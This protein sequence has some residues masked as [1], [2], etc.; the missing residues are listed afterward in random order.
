M[1]A[2]PTQLVL[3]ISTQFT[4]VFRCEGD[5]PKECLGS[6]ATDDPEYDLKL[7]QVLARVQTLELGFVDQEIWLADDQ[8][9]QRHLRLEA[10]ARADRRE[11][12]GRA[13]SAIT[14]FTPADLSF[15]LGAEDAEGYT[16]VAAVPIKKL[17]EILALAQI[18][19][20]Q[21]AVVTSSDDI[22]GFDERPVW[23]AIELASS[24]W[25][26]VMQAACFM[27]AIMVPFVLAGAAN[28]NSDF[29]G[30]L[31]SILAFT[32]SFSGDRVE[33]KVAAINQNPAEIADLTRQTHA[34]PAQLAPRSDAASDLLGAYVQ[35]HVRDLVVPAPAHIDPVSPPLAMPK[36]DPLTVPEMP[37]HFPGAFIVPPPPDVGASSAVDGEPVGMFHDIKGIE[38]LSATQDLAPLRKRG[39]GVQVANLDV[40]FLD[41]LPKQRRSRPIDAAPNAMATPKERPLPLLPEEIYGQDQ[42]PNMKTPISSAD[43]R[44]TR[45]K[46]AAPVADFVGLKATKMD[47]LEADIVASLAVTQDERREA[48]IIAAANA[49]QLPGARIP[50]PRKRDLMPLDDIGGAVAQISVDELSRKQSASIAADIQ[51]PGQESALQLAL[52][53][54]TIDAAMPRDVK[55]S[56]QSIFDD[57]AAK[58]RLASLMVFD[59]AGLAPAPRLRKLPADTADVVVAA[60]PATEPTV[61][62]V[63]PEDTSVAAASAVIE[64]KPLETTAI[65]NTAIDPLQDA[66][67]PAPKKRDMKKVPLGGVS[68]SAG[69]MASY[70]PLKRPSDLAQRAAAIVEKRNSAAARVAARQTPRATT[71]SNQLQIPGSARVA[72]VATIRDGLD[73]GNLSLI[74]IFG[75]SSNRHALLR[76]AQG[77]IEKVKN[78][79]RISGWTVAGIGDDGVR[80]QKRSQTKVLRLP[81]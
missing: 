80:I 56:M 6:V 64:N 14:P 12:A 75:K 44:L 21:D 31:R 10:T 2:D 69:V 54:P 15:A 53:Q 26:R 50:N 4:S 43:L 65:E 46:I 63:T 76:T 7:D 61:A 9:I 25:M 58:A 35:R 27:L 79:Q 22:E 55:Q 17:D 8:I 23:R 70:L 47:R 24:S 37:G 18:A 11:E 59:E 77:R 30:Q 78:G 66:N 32:P 13:L 19:K 60:A 74:G 36:F 38:F 3:E 39:F 41:R 81:N 16:A 51:V 29:G 48:A 67:I 34:L 73:L 1:N 62:P 57:R 33:T 72:S 5:V 71:P 42:L 28:K 40:L 45:P 49:A 68:A 20:F 52:G